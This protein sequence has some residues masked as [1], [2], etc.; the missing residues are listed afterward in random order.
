MDAQ[1]RLFGHR[2]V[3]VVLL[4]ECDGAEVAEPF[5]DASAVVEAVDVLEE[6]QVPLGPGGED[7]AAEQAAAADRRSRTRQ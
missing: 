3:G 4:L 6:R 2:P 7:A 5:L 1:V